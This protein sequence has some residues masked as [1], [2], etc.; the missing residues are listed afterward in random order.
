MF[1]TKCGRELPKDGN[2]CACGSGQAE[3]VVRNRTEEQEWAAD[4]TVTAAEAAAEPETTAEEEI[5]PLEAVE[6]EEPEEAIATEEPTC[7]P[8][9]PEAAPQDAYIP[10]V[11]EP[12]P[13]YA[14]PSYAVQQENPVIAAIRSVAGSPLFLIAAIVLSLHFVLNVV[15]RLMPL[16]LTGMVYGIAAYLDSAMPGIGADLLREMEPVMADLRAA[17][18]GIT[19]ISML[20]MIVPALTL[21]AVWMI[22]G[23]AKQANSPTTAGLTILQVLQ[24]LAVIGASFGVLLGLGASALV[25]VLLQ[26]VGEELR[27]LGVQTGDISAGLT[28]GGIIAAV[29]ILTGVVLSLIYT[30][31]VLSTVVGVKKAIRTGMVF[32]KASAFVAVISLLQGIGLV[33]DSVAVFMLLGWKAA[34]LNVLAG[35]VNVLFAVCIFKYNKAVKPLLVPKHAVAMPVQPPVYPQN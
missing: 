18:A 33:V 11:Q 25:I 7:I 29:V 22:Y 31:K 32:K 15:N 16:D 17:Q 23:S 9:Q 14:A 3:L 21:A 4:E 13:V 2:P 12:S 5:L 26:L 28:V 24:I 35:V 19:V 27:Y 1:C 6:S 20:G 30:A 10:P 34:V 8:V